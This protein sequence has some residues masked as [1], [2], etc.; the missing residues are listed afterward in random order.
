M[1]MGPADHHRTN[2]GVNQS[3]YLSR[4]AGDRSPLRIR[5]HVKNQWAGEI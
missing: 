5:L 4:S 3:D 1:I 2:V